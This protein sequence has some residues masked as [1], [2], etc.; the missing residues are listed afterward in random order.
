MGKNKE[1]YPRFKKIKMSN[2]I[3]KGT[4]KKFRCKMGFHKWGRWRRISI[5]SSNVTDFE[6]KCKLCGQVKRKTKP[7][8]FSFGY[9]K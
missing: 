6:R 4:N 5:M 3:R 9:E 2:A 7:R 8:D 1:D